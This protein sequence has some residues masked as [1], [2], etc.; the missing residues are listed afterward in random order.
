MRS[1][2]CLTASTQLPGQDRKDI[3][4]QQH[5]NG[6]GSTRTNNSRQLDE[7]IN[8]RIT[9]TY[10][11]QLVWRYYASRVLWLSLLLIYE[12]VP[13]CYA[14]LVLPA[15]EHN[16]E[17]ATHDPA[18]LQN[19]G[20]AL[21]G[22]LGQTSSFFTFL[23]TSPTFEYPSDYAIQPLCTPE[24]REKLLYSPSDR[25]MIVVQ[26]E[27]LQHIQRNEQVIRTVRRLLEPLYEEQ[28]R[29]QHSMG[30]GRRDMVD[31]GMD[32]IPS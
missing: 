27:E 32:F 25:T 5:I 13:G 15:H 16:L 29:W 18:S 9:P 21:V 14:G 6:T 3:L 4:S 10:R 2:Q 19:V 20:E 8:T 26:R 7:H 11:E 1:G 31:P 22:W 12:H 17:L 30:E 24:V 28:Q 23:T